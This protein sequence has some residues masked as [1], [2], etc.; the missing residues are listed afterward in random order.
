V[1]SSKIPVRCDGVVLKKGVSLERDIDLSEEVVGPGE[2][3]EKPKVG[4]QR[5]ARGDGTTCG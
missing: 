2:T 3:G 5:A 1:S 4:R